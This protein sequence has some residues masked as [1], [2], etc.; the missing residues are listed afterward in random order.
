ME[1]TLLFNKWSEMTY[2]IADLSIFVDHVYPLMDVIPADEDDYYNQ[3]MVPIIVH[4]SQ[5]VI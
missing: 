4:G 1:D 5:M 3:A 2:I